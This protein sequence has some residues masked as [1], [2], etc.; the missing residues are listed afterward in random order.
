MCG[1][2]DINKD[3]HVDLLV[4]APA[5]GTI[6]GG[7]SHVISGADWSELGVKFN[8]YTDWELGTAIAGGLDV[9]DDGWVDADVI[10]VQPRA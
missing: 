9:S 2:G 5:V 1:A 7:W 10:A 6:W 4:G 3:G 8:G